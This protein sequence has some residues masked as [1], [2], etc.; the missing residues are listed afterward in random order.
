MSKDVEFNSTP[1]YVNLNFCEFFYNFFENFAK[2]GL[3]LNNK[4]VKIY[5][6]K[7]PHKFV[8]VPMLFSGIDLVGILF[9]LVKLW[10]DL[11]I[12]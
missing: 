11:K 3:I 7:G 12:W 1:E 8:N 4:I 6:N 5:K 2:I 10:F 9:Y